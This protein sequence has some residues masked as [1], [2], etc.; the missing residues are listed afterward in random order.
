[1]T[2]RLAVTFSAAIRAYHPR[3][4]PAVTVRQLA[5]YLAQL[6]AQM[7]G[8]A[9]GVTLE[10]ARPLNPSQ[11][12]NDLD[13]LGSDRLLIVTTPAQGGDLER[14]PR[15]GEQVVKFAA[16]EFHAQSQGKRDLVIGKRDDSVGS[17]P[18]V[19]LTAVLPAPTLPF[20]SRRCVQLHYEPDS[21]LW[22][23]QRAGQ[24]RVLIDEYELDT[25]PVPLRPAQWLR[26]Y[27]ATDEPGL[28]AQPLGTLLVTVETAQPVARVAPPPAGHYALT[29]AAGDE[30]GD[31]FL[32]TSDNLLLDE[33]VTALA[34]QQRIDL[35]TPLQIYRLRLLMPGSQLADLDLR[36][37][38]WLYAGVNTRYA[39]SVLRLRD[40]LHPELRYVLVGGHA[41]S[42]KTL[43]CRLRV[44]GGGILPDIDLYDSFVAQLGGLPQLARST[45]VQVIYRAEDQTWWA[46][47]DPTPALPVYVNNL[48]LTST[49]MQLTS[50]DVMTLGA[51]IQRFYTRL[52]IDISDRH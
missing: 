5:D 23:A 48:R 41:D 13:W 25:T 40:V 7:A 51:N 19:D 8:M 17:V 39:S 42:S 1:M 18:D 24:T 49:P 12:L 29:L 44:Q 26:F 31:L 2:R 52:E 35:T 4:D 30:N 21:R 32:N 11:R 14:A 27:R 9:T 36:A 43:G 45:L 28:V 47:T 33:V 34:R 46:H 37:E 3:L 16:G 38:D 10:W 6:E 15:P 20:V 50:G 22:M